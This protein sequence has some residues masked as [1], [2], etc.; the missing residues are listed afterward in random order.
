MNSKVNNPPETAAPRFDRKFIEDHQI[1]DRYLLGKLPLKGSRELENWCRANPQYLEELQL[2]QKAQGSLKL[3][4]A[5]GQP[6]DLREPKIPWWKTPWFQIGLIVVSVMCLL[7]LMVLLGRI[8]L[9][10]GELE[11][12]R[13]VAKQGS[14]TAPARIDTLSIEPDRVDGIGKARVSVSHAS[15]ALVD[16]KVHMGFTKLTSFRLTVEKKDQ[17]R[18]LVIDHL[19]RD[20]NGDLHLS[21]NSSGLSPG[22]YHVQVDG[23]PF[24]GDPIGMA[25]FI[26]AVT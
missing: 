19:G 23:L 21:F 22:E 13:T 15:R 8:A 20:S 2:G 7:A 12:V 6:Q 18:A 5:A 10:R 3:L 25:W 14:L 9:L 26:I 24:R 1:L 17:G 4:E 11:D 16:L